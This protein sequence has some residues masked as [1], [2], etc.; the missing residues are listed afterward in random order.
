MNGLDIVLVN[1]ITYMTGL[2]SGMY[3]NYKMCKK[4]KQDDMEKARINKENREQDKEK[5]EKDK[6]NK[7]LREKDFINISPVLA[8]AV[9]TAPQ[10]MNPNYMNTNYTNPNFL[11]SN[12]KITITSE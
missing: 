3:I 11:N 7:E 4:N 2:L 9:A 6:E 10:P 5:R 8:A 12:K 1:V